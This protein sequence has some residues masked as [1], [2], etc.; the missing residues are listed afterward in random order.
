MSHGDLMSLQTISR[1]RVP[2]KERKH[3]NS[4][5]LWSWS[6]GH[7]NMLHWRQWWPFYFIFQWTIFC[8]PVACVLVLENCSL[9]T[10]FVSYISNINRHLSYIFTWC[11][12]FLVCYAF[13]EVN[14]WI[15]DMCLV[16]SEC[17]ANRKVDIWKQVKKQQQQTNN[18][19]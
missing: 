11:F 5:L 18:P 19:Q 10:Q 12:G 16:I 7:K 15:S 9:I 17:L 6:C 14:V 2:V 8:S 1:D 13:H 4:L 3:R